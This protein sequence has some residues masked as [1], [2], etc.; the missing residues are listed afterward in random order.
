MRALLA[1]VTLLISLHTFSQTLTAE[2]V[3]NNAI[4]F[5]DPDNNWPSFFGLL[6]V[7]MQTPNNSDRVSLIKMDLPGEFFH[8]DAKR[9]DVTVTYKVEKDSCIALLNGTTAF[10][11]EEAETNRLDCERAKMYRDYYTYLYGL[12]M[13][14]KDEGTILH[15]AVER[16]SLNKKEYLVL[17][18]TYEESVGND[19]WYF[20]FD[21]TTFAMEAYQFYKTDKNG[22][23]KPQSGEY[24]LLSDYQIINKIKMPK[25][26][27]W[28]YNK[29]DHFLGVD[30][31]N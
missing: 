8:I 1:I 12:P 7:T 17:K 10:S 19:V 27:K 23:L 25:I 14:L 3:L 28:Y 21:E 5:H 24:I 29:D 2:Q 13:K 31:L 18:V 16:K 26:R 6:K 15:D 20:Y 9:D 30:I 22:K 4:K 11:K